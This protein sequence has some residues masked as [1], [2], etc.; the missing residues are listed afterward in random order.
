LDAVAS[1]YG[2]KGAITGKNSFYYQV[3]IIHMLF[4]S[5][6][7]PYDYG[8]II[9]ND[10]GGTEGGDFVG[11]SGIFWDFGRVQGYFGSGNPLYDTVTLLC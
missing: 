9:Y 8:Y 11:F 1:A 5:F 4:S 7:M 3:D 10:S 2:R 6:Y